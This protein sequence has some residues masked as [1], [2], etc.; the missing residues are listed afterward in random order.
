MRRFISLTL[1]A[2]AVFVARPALAGPLS[3]SATICSSL[4]V[5]ILITRLTSRT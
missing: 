4:T 5:R 3:A 2:S 1:I